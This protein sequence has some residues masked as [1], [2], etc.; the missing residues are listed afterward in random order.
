MKGKTKPTF[1][2]KK[3]IFLLVPVIAGMAIA[4]QNVFY[5][6][7]SKNVGIMGTVLLV[8]FSGLIFASILFLFTKYTFSD[9]VN[10]INWYMIIS[11]V[12]GVIVVSGITKSVSTNGLLVTIM[13]SV[14][15]QMLLGKIINHFGWFGVAKSPINPLQILAIFVMLA[16]VFIYQ[17]S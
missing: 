15:A 10:N 7:I 11:G 9:L 13:L 1:T 14:T 16:G 17:K 4:L 6:N 5:N 2:V 12:L 3:M 8:H